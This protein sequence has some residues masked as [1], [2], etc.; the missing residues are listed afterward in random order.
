MASIFGKILVI[1][2]GVIA[3]VALVPILMG[4]GT[5]GIIGGSAAAAIQS[6]IGNVVAGSI[7]ATVQSLGATG[8]IAGTAI[9]GASAAAVGAGTL[10]A[11][12]NK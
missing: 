5:A 4:F 10:V 9:G 8:V 7:F 11:T 6:S 12:D 3:T 1:G 2:G